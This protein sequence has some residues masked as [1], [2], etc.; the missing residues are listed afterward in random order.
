MKKASAFILTA[1]LI[2]AGLPG[3]GRTS[4]YLTDS[5]SVVNPVRPGCNE[6]TITEDFPESPPKNPESGP[7]YNKTVTINAPK[8][9]GYNVDCYVRARILY[10]N[11]DLGDAVILSGMDSSWVHASD[12]WYYYTKKLSEGGTTAPL[13]TKVQFDPSKL[14]RDTRKYAEDFSISIYEESVQAGSSPDYKNAW[15]FFVPAAA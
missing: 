11:S 15:A 12:G 1:A 2:A 7:V 5:E 3:I 9:S 4:S 13:F 6:T 10:S 14:T 8:S